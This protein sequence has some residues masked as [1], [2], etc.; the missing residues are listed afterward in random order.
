MATRLG[1]PCIKNSAGCRVVKTG[2]AWQLAASHVKTSP[3]PTRNSRSCSTGSGTQRATL[4]SHCLPFFNFALAI[5]R[6]SRYVR[7]SWSMS[8]SAPPTSQSFSVSLPRSGTCS[9]TSM[10]DRN[11]MAMLVTR[12]A[13]FETSNGNLVRWSGTAKRFLRNV[14]LP[15]MPREC[16]QPEVARGIK[17]ERS[18]TKC[19]EA[20]TIAYNCSE[21]PEPRA[22][23]RS[24]RAMQFGLR[25]RRR[26][27][28][29]PSPPHPPTPPPRRRR[30]GTPRRRH[31]PTRQA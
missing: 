27:P 3:R 28:I 19:S 8:P 5:S 18:N 1:A 31:R 17:P 13:M 6:P 15:W 22:A 20:N 9:N 29:P 7:T 26:P 30:S 4:P 12:S 10:T 25:A 24:R 2:R 14:V 11:A 23:T 16:P 21:Y